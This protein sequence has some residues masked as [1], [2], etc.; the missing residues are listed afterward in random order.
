MQEQKKLAPSI[1]NLQIAAISLVRISM[2]AQ[3]STVIR[4]QN[5]EMKK[6]KVPSVIFKLSLRTKT[7]FWWV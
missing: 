7:K 5:I 6:N 2:L 4:N 3:R 1:M